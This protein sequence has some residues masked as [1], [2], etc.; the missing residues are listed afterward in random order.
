MSN[1]KSSSRSGK[2]ERLAVIHRK[3]SETDI[4]LRLAIDGQGVAKISTGIPFFD[5]ML[6]ALTRHALFDVELKCQGD[7]EVD[8]HHSVEDCGI[9]LGQALA[10]ALG[11]KR[12]IRRFGHAYAPMDDALVRCVVD[13]SG[14]AFLH[15]DVRTRKLYAGDFPIQLL[16]EFFRAF[17][18]NALANVHLELLH[19][20]DAHHIMEASFKALAKALDA[21]CQID[22]RTGEIP[23]TKGKL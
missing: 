18:N 1:R 12:G 10:Q 20:R 4:Q 2:A 19:G 13:L 21:A 22:S 15:Y 23:S 6:T 9:A 3:T 5:H 8:F 7:L 16:E 14:R 17:T 11:D